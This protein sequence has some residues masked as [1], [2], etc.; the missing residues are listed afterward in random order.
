MAPGRSCVWSQWYHI[1]R[2]NPVDG[3]PAAEDGVPKAWVEE[4]PP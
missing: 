4:S 2:S 1:A 3:I